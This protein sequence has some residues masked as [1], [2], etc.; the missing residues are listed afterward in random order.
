MSLLAPSGKLCLAF[1]GL[2][3]L[4]SDLG[5]Q[6]IPTTFP[7]LRDYLER[8]QV[9][10]TL[11]T[12]FSFL[13]FPIHTQKVFEAAESTYL[14]DTAS[15]YRP[16]WPHLGKKTKKLEI[17]AL[18]LQY[19]LRYESGIPYLH[20]VSPMIPA[21]GVQSVREFGA[22]VKWG[23]WHIQLYPQLHL[24]QNLPFEEYPPHAPRSFFQR[25]RVTI[26]GVDSPIRH[27][28]GHIAR[29]LPGN[30]HVLYHLG[31]FAGGISTEN[32]WWGPGQFQPLLMGNNAPGFPH[33][34]LKTTRPARTFL[35]NFEGQYFV[36]GLTGSGLTHYSDGAYESVWRPMTEDNWR[37]F[38]GISITYSPRFLP[39]LSL[40][41]N[42]MFQVYRED[43]RSNIRAYFPLFAPLP[44]EGEGVQENVDLREAQ[45]ISV[46][47][48]WVIPEAK[49]KFYAEYIRNDHA[50]TWRDL[51][52]NP[53]HSRGYLL[54]FSKYIPLPKNKMVEVRSEMLHTENSINAMVRWPGDV[55]FY[56]YGLYD[57]YQVRHGLSN[58]GQILGPGT[59]NS[60]NLYQ[61]EVSL[62]EDMDK[63]GIRLERFAREQNFYRHAHAG[64]EHIRPW[65]DLAAGVVY[66]KHLGNL[67]ISGILRGVTA[68]NPNFHHPTYVR[69]PGIAPSQQRFSVN[70][71]FRVALIL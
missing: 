52:L 59:G 29:I 55:P 38:T 68:N 37:Y 70:S 9:S 30:S 40:G 22:S 20:G 43:M 24:A 12:D 61:L 33:F 71:T 50:L 48:R 66:E 67:L 49:F 32:F 10:N 54:G 16:V 36:G 25:R 35:G 41:A 53:E 62:I 14:V 58:R 39:G 56:T 13:Y 27:G 69:E 44:K 51:V 47:M 17:H 60:G 3:C 19:T 31:S 4:A 5:A 26:D 46:F 42:R 6:N 21:R 28:K 15:S 63:L 11:E 7:I 18:P 2:L 8:R 34:T 1:I 45:N 64:G 57:N 23:N 65:V